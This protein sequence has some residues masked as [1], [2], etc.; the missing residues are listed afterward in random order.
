MAPPMR[1]PLTIARRYIGLSHFIKDLSAL[2]GQVFLRMEVR[3]KYVE[4]LAELHSVE[5]SFA[6]LARS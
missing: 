1:C 5:L 3:V 6:S 4:R 2:Y